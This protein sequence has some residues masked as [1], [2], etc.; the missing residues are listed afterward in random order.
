LIVISKEWR[1]LPRLKNLA[2]A[3]K[4]FSLP[5]EM[6]NRRTSR[7]DKSENS[8]KC[9][10]REY[11]TKDYNFYVYILTNWSDE[12]MYIGMTNNLERR[13]Y[14]HKNK[15]VDGFTKKYNVNNDESYLERFEFGMA[16]PCC[17]CHFD[18]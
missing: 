14:E 7:H 13:L 1:T 10:Y 9:H 15:L 17:R 2:G 5:L 12:V 4:D 8:L 16:S 6:T 18:K 11:L 3:V